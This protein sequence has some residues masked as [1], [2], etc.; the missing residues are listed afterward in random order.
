MTCQ[1]DPY[2]MSICLLLP[3]IYNWL[4]NPIDDKATSG[5]VLIID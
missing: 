3:N 4:S 5:L 2:I 1:R